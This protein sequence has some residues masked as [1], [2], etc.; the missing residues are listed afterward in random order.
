M[1]I[2]HFFQQ[3]FSACCFSKEANIDGLCS[4]I[5]VK[6]NLIVPVAVISNDR[7]SGDKMS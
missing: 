7:N 5:G 4:N 2:L 1:E 3:F 6:N